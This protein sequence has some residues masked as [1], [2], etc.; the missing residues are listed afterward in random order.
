MSDLSSDRL[1]HDANRTSDEP[2]S[3]HDEYGPLTGHDYDGIQEYDNP[4]PGWWK[5]IFLL[6][7]LFAPPYFLYYHLGAEGR[8]MENLYSAEVAAN[9]RLQFAEIGELS[10]DTTT[11]VQYMTDPVWL[12]VGESVYR[13]NCISC[14]GP[15]GG[16]LIG[17]N[18]CDDFYKG[19]GAIADLYTVIAEGAAGGAMPAWKNR[20]D[21]N[22]RVLVAAYVASLRGSDP[23][24]GARGPEG[25]VIPAWPVASSVLPPVDAAEAA[26]SSTALATE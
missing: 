2:S 12:R 15:L 26:I 14:H 16:G 6:T 3:H 21:Q 20:L 18:L 10:G 23:G 13:A 24:S 19:I 11:L 9:A 25:R 8:S 17:P 22:E 7:V 4:M 1:P 5:L